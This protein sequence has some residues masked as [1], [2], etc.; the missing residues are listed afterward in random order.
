MVKQADRNQEAALADI[1]CPRCYKPL[2]GYSMR[3]RGQDRYARELR[4]YMGW[5]THCN[6]G[7]EVVQF[8]SGDRWT[9]HKWR[10]YA[11]IGLKNSPS[12]AW[13]VVTKLPDPPVVV[14]GPGGDYDKAY[15]PET[16]ELVKTVLHALKG[17]AKTVENLLKAAGAKF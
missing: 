14:T 5:C 6:L 12:T 8:L 16:I 7:S 15:D 1:I 13:Q 3:D 2:S 9:L 17:C 4:C 11:H 10:Y